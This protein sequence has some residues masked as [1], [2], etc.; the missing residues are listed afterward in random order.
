MSEQNPTINPDEFIEQFDVFATKPLDSYA[1][2]SHYYILVREGDLLFSFDLAAEDVKDTARVLG[3][4]PGLRPGIKELALSRAYG[5]LVK[6]IL[7]PFIM[8]SNSN[9][10]LPMGV[11]NK[12]TI[13]YL[14]RDIKVSR[15]PVFIPANEFELIPSPSKHLTGTIKWSRGELEVKTLY[16]GQ[17]VDITSKTDPEN[18]CVERENMED[19]LELIDA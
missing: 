5:R 1:D 13:A 8:N 12:K 18:F 15:F 9:W 11:S 4:C 14:I 19:W 2:L 3:S 17:G 16:T 10:L 7:T 6:E